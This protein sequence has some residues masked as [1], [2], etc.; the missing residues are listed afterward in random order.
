[1]LIGEGEVSGLEVVEAHL[2][3]VELFWAGALLVLFFMPRM[4]GCEYAPL[5]PS[6]IRL[7]SVAFGD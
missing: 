6:E 7:G 4:H 5:Q 3:L 1:L 2:V